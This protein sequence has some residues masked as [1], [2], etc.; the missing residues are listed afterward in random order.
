MSKLKI[1]ITKGRLLEKSAEMFELAGIECEALRNPG[2]Q[3][4]LPIG[5]GMMEAVLAK[6]ADVITY[7]ERGVCELGIVGKDTIM[8]HATNLYEILDLGFGRCRFA[9]AGK[10]DTDF[11]TNGSRRVAAT[12]YINVSKRYFERKHIDAE[13]IKIEGS[14]ELAPLLGLA[15][16]IVDLVETGSTLKANGLEILEEVCPVSARLVVNTAALKL[17][18]REI[19]ELTTKLAAAAKEIESKK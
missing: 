1:A 5:N 12:K 16:V 19:E 2:R 6:S 7:T 9:V 4:V 3:L 13:L 10:P 18:K 17:R 15:D 8:E 14:V 11:F